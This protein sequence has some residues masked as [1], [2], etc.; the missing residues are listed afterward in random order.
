MVIRAVRRAKGKICPQ[1]SEV[2]WHDFSR[3]L[4]EYDELFPRF[5]RIRSSRQ[6]G[7]GVGS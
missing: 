3:I 6:Y 4:L 5:L 2:S 1:A 7:D